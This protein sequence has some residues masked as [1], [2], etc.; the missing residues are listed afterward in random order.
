MP[1]LAVIELRRP[2]STDGTRPAEIAGPASVEERAPAAR[3]PTAVLASAA[4][5]G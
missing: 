2:S 3:G 1:N 5:A 4:D